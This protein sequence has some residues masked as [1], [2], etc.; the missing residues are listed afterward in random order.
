MYLVITT[1]KCNMKTVPP[2][3]SLQTAKKEVITRKG[4]YL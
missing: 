3:S 4:V 1:E 2:V